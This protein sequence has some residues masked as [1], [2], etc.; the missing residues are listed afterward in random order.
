V[1]NQR[2]VVIVG[3]GAFGLASGVELQARGWSVT[4]I[5]PGPIPHP[6][7]SSTDVSKVVRM[8]YGGDA[9]YAELARRALERWRRWNAG[10]TEPLYHE[11]GFLLMSPV[12]MREGSFEGDGYRMLRTLGHPLERIDRQTLRERFPAWNAENWADGYLNPGAGW[13]ESGRVVAELAGVARSAGV[14]VREG[15]AFERLDE[16]GS[17]V[18]G[19]VL[20]GGERLPAD[21]VVVAAGAWTPQLL[22][23]LGTALRTVGQPVLHFAPSDPAPFLAERFPVWSADI[24][25]TGF[26][27]FP[28]NA[29]GVGKVGH[30]GRGT[31]MRPDEPRDVDDAT[32]AHFREFLR[33]TFPALAAAPRVHSRVCMYCD[34]FDGD[35]WIDRDPAREGL[36]VAAGGSGH[37]F[38]F[39]PILGEIVADVV[40]GRP[41]PH[42]GRFAWRAPGARRAE[43]A[44]HG[45]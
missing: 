33:G 19:V 1:A 43:Q 34:S 25:N 27:G 40:E 20:R 4:L 28:V 6:R 10:R 38:K 15:V 42:G 17:R 14:L 35:F 29:A 21:R 22:P 12:E 41:D 32:E 23:E 37:A 16:R 2:S 30:H 8:D 3:G 18:G 39:T 5:D 24:A 36:V 13:V 26:Y 11:V 45:G 44:R 9:F 7:A 31:A